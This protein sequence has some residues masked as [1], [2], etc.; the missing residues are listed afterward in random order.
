MDVSQVDEKK[1]PMLI[2]LVCVRKFLELLD[3]RW[4]H[5][6]ILYYAASGEGSL[7]SRQVTAFA[8]PRKLN[9]FTSQ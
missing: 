2:R 3:S 5:I 6:Y 8:S 4:I 1:D 7:S 9:M